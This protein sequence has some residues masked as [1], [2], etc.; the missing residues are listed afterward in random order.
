[1]NTND[2]FDMDEDMNRFL[3][4]HFIQGTLVTSEAIR[5]NI[6]KQ[7]ELTK[8]KKALTEDFELGWKAAFK[9]IIENLDKITDNLP[10]NCLKDDEEFDTL[11][12]RF[13][14]AFPKK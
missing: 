5:K 6:I 11:Y 12:K 10:K 14:K 13:Q 8:D 4:E 1:M 2:I 3:K 9:H 7:Y